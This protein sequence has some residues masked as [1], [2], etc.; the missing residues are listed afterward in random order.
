MCSF[1][2]PA[3]PLTET[4]NTRCRNRY[5]IYNE[6]GEDEE[7]D[8]EADESTSDSLPATEVEPVD[9]PASGL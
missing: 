7:E 5:A 8:T 3:E 4:L 1:V 2:Q 6:L 9:V